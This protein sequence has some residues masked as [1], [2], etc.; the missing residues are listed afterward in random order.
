MIKNLVSKALLSL[1][2][3]KDARETLEARQKIKKAVK[4]IETAKE[5][6]DPPPDAGTRGL[7][8]DSAETRALIKA[9]I[10]AAE[11]EFVE[12]FKGKPNLTPE[13]QA[14]INQA[15][16]VQRAKAHVFDDLTQEQRE[17]LYVV[18]LKSLNPDRDA[19]VRQGASRYL[20]KQ[21]KKK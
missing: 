5:A 6:D 4:T 10:A 21:L 13:R 18:A 3:D 20:K 1:V 2:M 9:S 8:G 17:K 16:N 15:L 19:K 11:H 12:E 14:L 7:A